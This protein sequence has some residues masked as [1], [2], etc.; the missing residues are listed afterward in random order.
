MPMPM[1][2]PDPLTGATGDDE[3]RA[4]LL[5]DNDVELLTG[6]A[7]DEEPGPLDEDADEGE[8]DEQ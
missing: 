6:Q 2:R 5:D 8:D 7:K 3:R 1:P 4:R